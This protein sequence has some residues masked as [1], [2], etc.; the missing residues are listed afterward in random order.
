MNIYH[1][2]DAALLDLDRAIQIEPRHYYAYKNRG[3]LKAL[4]EDYD[5][6][7]KKKKTERDRESRSK[8]EKV[9]EK[10]N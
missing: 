9:I 6:M 4:K 2:H 1:N 5:G 7:K 3:C 8:S 10:E